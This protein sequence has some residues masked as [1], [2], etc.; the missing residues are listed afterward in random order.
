MQ[1]AK[2][3]P[4]A[5][6]YAL[7]IIESVENERLS[8]SGKT[9]T[10]SVVNINIKGATAAMPDKTFYL[11]FLPELLDPNVVL[12]EL[13][14]TEDGAKAY[15]MFLR[16]IKNEH[17]NSTL[18][19]ILGE[20]FAKFEEE[21][22]GLELDDY[23]SPEALTTIADVLREHLVGVEVGYVLRQQKDTLPDGTK[24]LGQGY[25]VESFFD[26]S[27]ENIEKIEKRVAKQRK[28]PKPVLLWNEAAS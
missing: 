25:G 11:A 8:A 16:H 23:T 2:I 28:E 12:S 5:D 20:N 9:P 22:D 17:S 3:L 21:I 7:G 26:P 4:K 6:R 24:V 19:T 14:E 18:Q 10:Y 1:T 27:D 13:A 15:G